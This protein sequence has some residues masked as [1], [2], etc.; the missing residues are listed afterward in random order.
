MKPD[1]LKTWI[2]LFFRTRDRNVI[3]KTF[4]QPEPSERLIPLALMGFAVTVTLFSKPWIASIIFANV[5]K[6]NVVL[7]MKT[8]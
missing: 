1:R 4:T 6:C 2:W 8:L 7:Q 3:L 5:R